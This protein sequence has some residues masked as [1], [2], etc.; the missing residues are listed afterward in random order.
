MRS[1]PSPQRA[2]RGRRAAFP[3]PGML[4]LATLAALLLATLCADVAHAEVMLAQA[5]SVSDVLNNIRGW[6]AGILAL[7]AT[8]FVMIGGVRYILAGGDPGEV[9]KGKTAL[10]AAAVGYMLAA[11]AALVVAVLKGF[12]GL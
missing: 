11:L 9:E 2:R 6:L 12:V 8:L 7:L 4:A 5:K 10:K 3:R 1:A